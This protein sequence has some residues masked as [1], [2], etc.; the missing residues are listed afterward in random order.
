MNTIWLIGCGNIGFRHLQAMLAMR[1]AADITVI[2]PATALHPRIMAELAL[3]RATSHRVSIRADLPQDGGADLAVVAT[4]APQRAGIVRALTLGAAPRAVILEKI[5]AQTEAD[6]DAIAADLAAA[7]T[8]AQV[9]CP[10]RYFP[11]YHALRARLAGQGPLSVRARGAQFGLASNAVHFLDLLE[12]LNDSPLVAVETAG[13]EPGGK[14]SKRAGF[15]EIY[16]TL[17]ARLANGAS[18][19]V[20]CEDREP[21]SLA[22]TVST[23]AGAQYHIDEARGTLTTA[24]GPE[25][26]ATRFVSQT[27]EVYV[28]ALAGQGGLTP[29]AASICQHRLYL[30][31]MRQHFGLGAGQIVPVS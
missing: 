24:D 27:P 16:G 22:I 18:M 19:D 17:A 23:A 28:D 1:D 11:G 7:G 25:E 9:N 26:F 5:L 21:L 20:T 14:P 10:R 29:L 31:R 15:L 12:Y 8:R 13:L 4:S 6:L 30:A 3:P 2:E